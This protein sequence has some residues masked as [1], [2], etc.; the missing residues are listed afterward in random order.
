[1]GVRKEDGEMR[2]F[3]ART[4]PQRAGLRRRPGLDQQLRHA[5]PQQH[6]NDSCEAQCAF[7]FRKRSVGEMILQ[8]KKE[9][10]ESRTLTEQTQ[11]PNVAQKMTNAEKWSLH[12]T[13]LLGLFAERRVIISMTEV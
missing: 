3:Q 10:V 9:R 13:H 11:Q 4:R 6:N 5:G 12:C 8:E 7:D 1:M 2:T